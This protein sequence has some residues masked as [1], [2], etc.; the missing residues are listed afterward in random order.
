MNAIGKY[1]LIDPDDLPSK[2][3]LKESI[4]RLRKDY[5]IIKDLAPS[6]YKCKPESLIAIAK[7]LEHILERESS[8]LRDGEPALCDN[9]PN[10]KQ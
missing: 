9:T 4:H 5:E 3:E 1:V 10:L 6:K 8:R 7:F 2:Q